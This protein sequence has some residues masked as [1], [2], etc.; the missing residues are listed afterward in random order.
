M[1]VN[2]GNSRWPSTAPDTEGH[3]FN[4]AILNKVIPEQQQQLIGYVSI[5][6]LIP[7][8][9][10]GYSL[11]PGFWGKG[12]AIEAFQILLKRWWELPGRLMQDDHRCAAGKV[13]ANCDKEN[14]GSCKILR[15][16]GFEVENEVRFE[17]DE[18]YIWSL[19]RSTE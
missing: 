2:H 4:F 17:C 9:M 7:C 10:I 1:D 11:L 3:S 18:R 6:T 16:C 14:V 19:G 15:K 8:P 13:Y 12:F 5:N